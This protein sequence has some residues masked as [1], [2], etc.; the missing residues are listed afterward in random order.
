MVV[1]ILVCPVCKEPRTEE[2]R[3][4]EECG[5]DY[6]TAGPVVSASA[7]TVPEERSGFSGPILWLVMVFW[8][9]LALGA[10]FFLYTALWTI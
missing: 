1:E 3:Y 8:V 4:C 9:A 10:L 6:E 7:G 5:H 2:I